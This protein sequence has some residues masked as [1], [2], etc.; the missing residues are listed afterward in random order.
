M[1]YTFKIASL[2]LVALLLTA[3]GDPKIDASSD[4]AMKKSIQAIK[5]K[6]TEEKKEEFKEAL[7]GIYMSGALASMG[8]D[9]SEEEVQA[10]I[11]ANLDGKT[12]D[13]L[14]AMVKELKDNRNR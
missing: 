3:C 10:A 9:K 8:G 7:F 6:L 14:F 11:L 4:E 13:D 12:A 5:E 1:K 2:I